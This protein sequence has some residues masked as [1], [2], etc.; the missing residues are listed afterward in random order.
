MGR[1][2]SG[3]P[4]PRGIAACSEVFPFHPQNVPS[5]PLFALASP[6]PDLMAP[7]GVSSSG[8]GL[9]ARV[10]QAE[11]SLRVLSLAFLILG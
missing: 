10:P 11:L 7:W 6:R 8:D 9:G 2:S 1:L 3:V 4:A 5:F